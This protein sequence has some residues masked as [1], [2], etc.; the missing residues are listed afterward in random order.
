[1]LLEGWSYTID[2]AR[3]LLEEG[4]S[5]DPGNDTGASIR[6]FDDAFA[7]ADSTSDQARRREA[8]E[9][10]EAII[11]REGFYAPLYYTNQGFLVHPSVRGWRDNSIQWID[12]R[13]LYLEP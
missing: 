10:M 5:D 9:R 3:D 13:E 8:F 7:A 2:D 6:D 1:V 4:I 11:A 12:W